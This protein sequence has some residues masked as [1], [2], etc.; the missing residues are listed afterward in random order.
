MRRQHGRLLRAKARAV[1][2]GGTA[3][4]QAA[5]ARRQSSRARRL[6]QRTHEHLARVQLPRL[7]NGD[8]VSA[9]AAAA[10]V[11]QLVHCLP[12]VHQAN[13]LVH[14]Q[15]AGAGGLAQQ[16]RQLLG[17]LH[18][19]QVAG[20]FGRGVVARHV[21]L[22]GLLLGANGLALAHGRHQGLLD[23]AGN[24]LLLGGT[25][26]GLVLSGGPHGFLLGLH[27][28]RAL[29]LQA[30]RNLALLALLGVSGCLVLHPGSANGCDKCGNF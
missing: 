16:P 10:K 17:L 21:A 28:Q 7:L 19:L 9:L 24:L 23:V 5:T 6:Q 2:G 13:A 3:A 27:L 25:L 22:R 29:R 8:V 11:G 15:A 1:F 20:S 12:G 4:A 26:G 30:G 14:A 18:R